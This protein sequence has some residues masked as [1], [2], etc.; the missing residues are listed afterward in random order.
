MLIPLEIL[1]KSGISPHILNR[2]GKSSLEVLAS[3]PW[4]KYVNEAMILLIRYGA[5]PNRRMK[6]WQIRGG[7]LLQQVICTNVGRDTTPG[8]ED[9]LKSTL[10]MG[11]D[12][13]LRNSDGLNAS[14]LLNVVYMDLLGKKPQRKDLRKEV[15]ENGP[16]RDKAR[17]DLNKV[18]ALLSKQ[19]P[20]KN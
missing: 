6:G 5:S 18:L 11:A 7:T 20:P 12:P 14:E 17:E 15:R 16:A 2:F 19:V 8:I 1:L 3:K 9:I 10:A 4:N 13:K